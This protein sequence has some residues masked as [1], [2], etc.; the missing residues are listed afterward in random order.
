MKVTDIILSDRV[1]VSCELFPPKI[2]KPLADIKRIVREIAQLHPSFVSVTCSAGGSTGDRTVEVAKEVQLV[3]G[4]PALA[5]MT[6][7][8]S[9][10]EDVRR[11]LKALEAGGVKNILALRGDLPA[12]MSQRKSDFLHASDLIEEI[13]RLGDFCVGGACYP[14]GHPESPNKLSD[15][16]GL[17]R[18]V[19]SGCE[20]LTTQMF[21]DNNILYNFLF[22]LL[23]HGIEIP[24]IAGIMPITN[25]KQVQST[26]K[27]SGTLLPPRFRA[28]V[29]RFGENP[30]AMKQAGIAYA[31]EQ[32]IDLIANSVSHIH[33]YTMNKPDI[34]G[35]I[36]QNLSEIFQ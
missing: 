34:A 3:N 13:K 36:M 9:D 27:L 29:D 22:R 15:L 5:H 33:I 30:A 10:R 20:F 26:L 4:V 25:A 16:D 6:C 1:T 31:T 17:K 14:E 11:T 35:Q 19:D 23:K 24:V 8:S 21:F 28:I 7:V 2:G 18:K 32:I 12:D